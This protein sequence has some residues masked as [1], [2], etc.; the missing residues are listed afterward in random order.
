MG[1]PLAAPAPGPLAPALWLGTSSWSHDSW[2]GLIYP[3]GTPSGEY[4]RHYAQR[5]PTVEIDA[6]FYRTPTASMIAAWKERT[7]PGFLFAAKAP[8]VITHEKLLAGCEAELDQFLSVMQGLGERLGPI[9][10]QFRYFRK[11]EMAPADFLARLVPFLDRLPRGGFRFVVEIRNKT[12]VTPALLDVLASRGVALAWIDHPWFWDPEAL[13]AR[14]GARSAAFA[15][16]RWLGDRV[17]IEKVT[18]EW[19][20]TVVDRTARL[21]AWAR[22]LRAALPQE[23][24][25]FG[26]FNN[27]FAGCAIESVDLFARLWRESGAEAAGGG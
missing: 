23:V 2:A 9:L 21:R 7:P 19:N 16:V 26:Y 25:I 10:F 22:A 3:P 5:F 18:R 8:Q 20:R 11:G 12:W 24:P 13:L 15:Y 1:D 27:H 4:I 6:T 17:A 14:P